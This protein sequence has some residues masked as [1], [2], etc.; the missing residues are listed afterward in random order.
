MD[1]GREMW[2]SNVHRLLVDSLTL[3]LVR[4]AK[5]LEENG[6]FLNADPIE[7]PPSENEFLPM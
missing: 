4:Y 2:E 7:E 3:Q 1:I 6:S 5:P